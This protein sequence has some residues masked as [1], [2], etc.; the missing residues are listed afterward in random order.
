M[1]EKFISHNW[2]V[3]SENTAR[4]LINE[5]SG[6]ASGNVIGVTFFDWLDRW[7]MDGAP[8]TQNPGT[9]S[10]PSPDGL[11]HEEYFG[12]ISMGD[13]SD[14]LMRQPRSSYQYLKQEWTQ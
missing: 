8:S 12:I 3:I 7:N 9:R 6:S 14:W 13:G 5:K 11:R 1:Q 2:A 4:A 10:W